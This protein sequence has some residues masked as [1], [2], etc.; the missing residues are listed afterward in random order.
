MS[1]QQ[2]A[3]SVIRLDLGSGPFPTEGYTGVDTCESEHPNVVH[4]NLFDGSRWPW[5]DGCVS[6]LRA[7]HVIE[8]IPHDQ[9]VVGQGVAKIITRD[10]ATGAYVRSERL[11]N[12]TQDAFFW[13]FDEAY[14]VAKPGCRFELAWPDP[15]HFHAFQDPTHCRFIPV[16]ALHYLSK[17]GRRALHVT[18][19]RVAC[20]WRVESVTRL[21]EPSALDIY[22]TPEEASRH[23]NAFHEIRATLIKQE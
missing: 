18:Q 23:C 7:S 21:G 17:E 14:R 12:H 15:Q 8:H 22:A 3:S 13:F 19:Y 2:P 4:H 11:Y 10:A 6:A 5:A 9:I 1:E 20:D 16:A